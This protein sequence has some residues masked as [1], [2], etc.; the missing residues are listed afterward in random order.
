ME[1][2]KSRHFFYRAHRPITGSDSSESPISLSFI[3]KLTALVV[4]KPHT[5]LVRPRAVRSGSGG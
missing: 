4:A 5:S 1:I 2:E 3:C